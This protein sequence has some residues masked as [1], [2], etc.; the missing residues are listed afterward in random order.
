MFVSQDKG[1]RFDL[2]INTILYTTLLV[3]ANQ[4]HQYN[5]FFLT[6]PLI[7]PKPT[8][9]P[10]IYSIPGTS[11]MVGRICTKIIEPSEF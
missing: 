1:P 9:S 11:W 7:I 2:F 4:N 6:K 10:F 5:I 8:S 3:L